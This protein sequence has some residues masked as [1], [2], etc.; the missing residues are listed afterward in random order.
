M[1]RELFPFVLA[2]LALLLPGMLPA[3]R[4]DSLPPLA[5]EPAQVM[6]LGTYHMANPGS[7]V[8]NVQ[9]DDIT[10]P[11]R[12]AQLETLADRLAVFNPDA[13]GVELAPAYADSLGQW[14]E[15]YLTGEP[16]PVPT[17]EVDQISFRLARQV[18]LDAVQPI[19]HPMDL[20]IKGVMDYATSHGMVARL[21]LARRASVAAAAEIERLQQEGTVV[22]ILSYLNS[23]AMSETHAFYLA[24]ATVGQGPEYPGAEMAANWYK[25]NLKI[26][27]N[28]WRLAEPGKHI[29]VVI[30]AGHG[31]LLRRFVEDSPELELVPA[32][33]YLQGEVNK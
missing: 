17:S 32:L 3:Q 8:V 16:L 25:R 9:A 30:G 13:I 6:I 22:D 12:Q 19:D 20:G 31:T 26:F 1:T 5:R 18:G 29:L 23:P 10:A 27:T 28:I 14:F 4:V 21:R 7:D 24:M 11:E 2:L 15:A 33:P